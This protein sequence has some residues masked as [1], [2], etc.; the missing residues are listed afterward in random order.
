MRKKTKKNKK[1]KMRLEELLEKSREFGELE[2][3]GSFYYLARNLLENGFK[4]EACI[5]LL[6]TWNTGN[7]RYW[8]NGIIKPLKNALEEQKRNFVLLQNERLRTADFG[9]ISPVMSEIYKELSQIKGVL[10]TGASKLMSLNNPELFIMW[11]E[12][13]RKNYGLKKSAKEYVLFHKM[14]QEAVRDI[15]WQ[16]EKPLAKAIDEFHYMTIT[17]PTRRR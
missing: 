4:L 8:S 12:P 17:L 5:L 15:D 14:M 3:E 6:A 2:A 13:I 1:R 10:Y 11:D 7:F 9:R 16:Y